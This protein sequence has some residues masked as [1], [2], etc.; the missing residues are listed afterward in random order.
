MDRM[1]RDERGFTLIE[2]VVVLVILAILVAIAVPSYLNFRDNA[3]RARAASDLHALVPAI[4]SYYAENHTFVGMTPG[5]LRK[6]YDQTIDAA[7]YAFTS[8]SA[9]TYCA[10]ATVDGM[11]AYKSGPSG[12]VR[13]SGKSCR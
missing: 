7:R 10:R 13:T 3:S 6:R 9:T 1:R 2:L 4:E 11:T 5:V 12:P 8:L